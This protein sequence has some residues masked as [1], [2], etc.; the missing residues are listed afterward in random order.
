MGVVY[1]T[2]E[3]YH[4]NGLICISIHIK[5]LFNLKDEEFISPLI[6]NSV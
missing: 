1:F 2:I 6:S 3:T 5:I 4:R